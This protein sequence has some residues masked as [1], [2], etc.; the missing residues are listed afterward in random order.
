MGPTTPTRPVH[1]PGSAP[2]LDQLTLFELLYGQRPRGLLDI[3]QEAWESQ[4]SSHC[5]RLRGAGTRPNG[6]DLARGP[7]TPRQSPATHLQPE[8]PG[9]RPDL[10]VQI[11][12]QVQARPSSY[13]NLLKRW[14]PATALRDAT[15]PTLS[16]RLTPAEVP[17]GK[18]LS[19]SQ[20]QDMRGGGPTPR[21]VLRTTKENR[22]PR[23]PDGTGS[24][25]PL[26]HSG[27]TAYHHPGRGRQHAADGGHQGVPQCLVQPR[28]PG[29]Q[30]RWNLL[31]LQRL[32]ETK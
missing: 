7:G 20:T 12:G 15:L 32:P 23:H 25:S 5:H 26:L 29:T 11:P 24:Q 14:Q 10:R 6:A 31:V 13:I 1:H 9:P 4:P 8:G 27:N 3:A 30:T 18:F 17:V 22:Q 21:R 19:P 16:A 2:G 28:G